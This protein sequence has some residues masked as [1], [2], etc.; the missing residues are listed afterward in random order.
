VLGREIERRTGFETRVSVLGYVQRGGSPTA[1]DR[2]LATRFGIKAVDLIANEEYGK[3][4]ALRGNKII[5][6]DM[7]E[8]LQM[9]KVDMDL[10][11]I[12]SIFFG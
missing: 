10:Y 4:V 2:V 9:K 8:G 12:A 6:V 7:S 11:D 1:A 5:G 3:M